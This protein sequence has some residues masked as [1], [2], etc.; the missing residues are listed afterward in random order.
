MEKMKKAI[1]AEF[2]PTARAKQLKDTLVTIIFDAVK[3]SRQM[4]ARPLP[5]A[6]PEAPPELSALTHDYEV[7]VFEA[8][9]E[10]SVEDL[11]APARAPSVVSHADYSDMNTVLAEL[12]RRRRAGQRQTV[13]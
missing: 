5:E 7:P 9:E 11:G 10:E 2:N 8:L 1:D 3:K 13:V 4:A 12:E 6:P